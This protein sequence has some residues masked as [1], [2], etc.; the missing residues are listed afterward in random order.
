MLVFLTEFYVSKRYYHS[1]IFFLLLSKAVL[2]LPRL[3][4]AGRRTGAYR[5]KRGGGN[6]FHYQVPHVS[7]VKR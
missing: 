2:C 7:D 4:V 3:G 6:P 5:S 1:E